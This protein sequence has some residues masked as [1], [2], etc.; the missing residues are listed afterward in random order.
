MK[1]PFAS[2][3]PTITEDAAEEAKARLERALAA[4]DGQRQAAVAAVTARSVEVEVGITPAEEL[5][6]ARAGLTEIELSLVSKRTALVSLKENA[7]ILARP[8]LVSELEAIAD[9][10]DTRWERSRDAGERV[11]RAA[12]ELI[13]AM[14]AHSEIAAELREGSSRASSNLRALGLDTASAPDVTPLLPS[15]FSD[16]TTYAGQ[17]TGHGPRGERMAHTLH[18]ARQQWER[19]VAGAAQPGESIHRALKGR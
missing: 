8:R 15:F 7:G 9:A 1:M 5:A 3:A 19:A 18:L 14:A 13:A 16:L 4:L 2:K 17:R 11:L 6:S 12:D 10:Q